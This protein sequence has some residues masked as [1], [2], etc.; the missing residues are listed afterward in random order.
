[1]GRQGRHGAHSEL[2]REH[3]RGPGELRPLQ[4]H[5]M[6]DGR[7]DLRRE[8][9]GARRQGRSHEADAPEGLRPQ[10]RHRVLGR[11]HP[12][13]HR[14]GRRVR[15]QA[16]HS[17]GAPVAGGLQGVPGAAGFPRHEAGGGLHRP[18]ARGV[19]R[20]QVQVRRHP[21]EDPVQRELQVRGVL[22]LRPVLHR[23]GLRRLGE[24]RRGARGAHVHHRLRLLR[25]QRRGAHRR[26][27][28]PGGRRRGRHKGDARGVHLRGRP[29][30]DAD[31]RRPCQH[32]HGGHPRH[33]LGQGQAHRAPE[34]AHQGLGPL[35]PMLF[36][37]ASASIGRFT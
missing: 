23:G 5:R 13:V 18:H 4:G 24:G 25:P 16:E 32:L 21:L 7:H 30:Q 29:L 20:Q 33:R 26:G 10:A 3:Q 36:L 1:M 31:D 34:G 14:R 22:R 12:L 11:L 37:Y 2:L 9:G 8:A 19:H 27:G 28:P 6:Q 15:R 35:R 17:E